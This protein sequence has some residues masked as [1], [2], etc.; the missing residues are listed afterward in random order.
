[1]DRHR[2]I[3]DVRVFNHQF[4]RIDQV[5]DGPGTIGRVPALLDRVGAARV[6][7]LTNRSLA[8]RTPLIRAM[9]HA[10]GTRHVTTFA[11]IGAHAPAADVE[12]A[13]VQVLGADADSLVGYG[14]S[15]VTD[16]TKIVVKLVADRT[17]QVLP[18][19]LV[20]TTLSA[21]EYTAAAG[22]TGD[23]PGVKSYVVDACMA[24]RA[25][26]LDPEVTRHTPLSL[27]LS[28]G[29]KTV[30]HAC[31]ALWG[32][33]RHPLTDTL[34]V[35]ALRRVVP[36]LERTAADPDDLDARRDAQVA[37]FLSMHCVQHSVVYLAHVL[38]H[39]IA[40][41]WQVQHGVTSGITLPVVLEHV[42]AEQPDGVSRIEDA[43]GAPSGEGSDAL[44]ALVAR[45]DLPGRL[46]DVGASRN[47]FVAVADAT[48]TAA[49]QLGFR[50]PDAATLVQLL[51]R[52]W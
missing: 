24:A 1:V 29:M 18:F 23:T 20:P 43:L 8:T 47:D 16:A 37:G 21:G 40:A 5:I 17:G 46:R 27:W 14:G 33:R 50:A 38:G 25:V 11:T 51:D 19:V 49:G 35:E 4:A 48:V 12:D 34:A 13:V 45:L 15:S 42:R 2:V 22:M 44:A 3:A 32:P 30:D 36:A 26:V 9:Q 41:R 31:E 10:L 39:Q 7:I 52:M 28:T 6:A